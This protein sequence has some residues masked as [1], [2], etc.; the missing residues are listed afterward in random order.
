MRTILVFFLVNLIQTGMVYG[1]SQATS[2]SPA[3]RSHA[4]RLEYSLGLYNKAVVAYKGQ[5]PEAFLD[6]GAGIV[7][8]SDR[9]FVMGL[10][11]GLPE[12]P[13]LQRNGEVVEVAYGKSEKIV[14]QLT[15]PRNGQFEVNQKPLTL[16]YGD[17]FKSNYEKMKTHILANPL[18][19]SLMERGIQ[20]LFS[21]L[22]SDAMASGTSSRDLAILAATVVGVNAGKIGARPNTPSKS[23]KSQKTKSSH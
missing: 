22:E 18:K 20:K 5:G 11:R 7:E 21:K 15:A 14:M 19:V 16:N 23:G 4:A 13:A 17:S 10:L 6:Q 2:T 1:Q 9:T 8:K 3:P 12:L